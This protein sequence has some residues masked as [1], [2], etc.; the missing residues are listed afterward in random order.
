MDLQSSVQ[1]DG[2]TASERLS[3]GW[4]LYKGVT[5][6]CCEIWSHGRGFEVRLREGANDRRVVCSSHH[7]LISVCVE[8]RRELICQG[9]TVRR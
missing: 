3:P 2:F 6:A 4:I 9:W 7:D 5:S 8:W 1:R